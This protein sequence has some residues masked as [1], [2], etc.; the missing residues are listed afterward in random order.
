M[1]KEFWDERFSQTD[2][3]YGKEPNDFL[4]TELADLPAGK[5]LF[6][7]EGEGRNAVYAAKLGW[8]ADAVD[9]SESAKQKA[10]KLAE[11][12]LVSVNYFI[13]DITA[14][15]P[16]NNFYDA[17]ALIFVHLPE[18][19]RIHVHKKVIDSLKP[20]GTLILESFEKDQISKNSGG[21]KNIDHLYSLE[22]IAT[23]FIDLDFTT[24]KKEVLHLTEGKFHSGEAVVI[25]FSGKKV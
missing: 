12:N 16:P 4:K 3:V 23:D 19:E 2:F 6:L 8:Q 10:L 15:T 25:R 21:P 18:E 9:F 13:A 5:I 20:G 14:F 1:E 22:N 7:G 11:E 24:F 17:A